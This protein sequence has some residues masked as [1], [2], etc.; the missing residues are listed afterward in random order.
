MVHRGSPLSRLHHEEES[1]TTLADRQAPR[2]GETKEEEGWR[3]WLGHG[4][5]LCWAYL[6]VVQG[7]KVVGLVSIAGQVS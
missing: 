5:R 2:V 1:R 6:R 3:A 7:G 4:A